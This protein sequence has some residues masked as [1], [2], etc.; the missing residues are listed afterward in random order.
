MPSKAVCNRIKDPIKRE[1]CLKYQGEFAQ[2]EKDISKK[3]PK[4]IKTGGY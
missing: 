1:R 4:K 3:S 2:S